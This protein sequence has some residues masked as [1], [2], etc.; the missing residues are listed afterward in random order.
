MRKIKIALRSILFILLTLNLNAKTKEKFAT[1]VVFILDRS[2]SMY[3][4]EKETIG[5]FNS[6]LKKQKKENKGETNVT[7]SYL[8]M[9]TKYCIIDYQLMK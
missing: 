1:D 8:I 7:L 9:N 4:L 2:G 5:G 3:G 6:I